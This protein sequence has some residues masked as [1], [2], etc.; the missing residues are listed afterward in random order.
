MAIKDLFSKQKSQSTEFR[1]A[2]KKSLDEFRE[3]VESSEEIKQIRIEDSLIQ[4]D[5]N[6]ASASSF[7]K[8]GSAKKYYEDAINRI[9]SQY[10]YDGSNKEKIEFRNDLTQLERHILDVDYP[11]ST[12]FAVFS[13]DGWGTSTGES[14]SFFVQSDTPEF[15]TAFGYQKNQI[16][17]TGSKQQQSFRLDFTTGFTVE[18]WLKKGTN[19]TG[20]QA[21][22]DIRDTVNRSASFGAYM[23]TSAPTSNLFVYYNNAVASNDFILTLPTGLGTSNT[24]WHHYAIVL[25]HADSDYKGKLYIDGEFSSQA[26]ATKTNVAQTGSLKLTI[27]ALGGD[28]KNHDSSIVAGYGKLS[29]SIDEFRFWQ[30]QRD[31]EQIGRNYFT[32]VNGG[33]NSDT[34]KVND[35]NT[36]KLASYFKFNEGKTGDTNFDTVALD[37]S[38]RLTNG[39]WTGY[40]SNSRDTG[41]AIV[42]SN[43]GTETGDP[44]IYST[45]PDVVTLSNNLEASGTQYDAENVGSLQDSLPLWMLDENEH[46]GGELLNLL[47]VMGSYLDSLYLQVTQMT[48]FHESEYQD[49]N[50]VTANPHNRRLL[51][52]LG[53]DIPEMFIDKDVLETIMDQ[54]DK[55]R[56]E[57]KL[58]DIKNLIYKNIYNNLNYINK[59]KGTVKSI[60]NL[61]R[62]YGIDDDL[63]NFN[64]YADKA[65]YFIEDDFKN[66]SIKFDSLDLTPFSKAQNSEGVIYNFAETGNANTAAFI[67][68]STDNYLGFTVQAN[69]IFPKTPS[70]YIDTVE[71][72]NP[73]VVTASVF[74]V[75][76]ASGSTVTTTIPNSNATIG[77]NIVR[78]DNTAKFHLTSSI[79]SGLSLESD[80]FYDVY[81]NSRWSLSLRVKYKGNDFSVATGSS[82]FAIELDGYNYTQDILENSFSLSGD[83]TN[84]NGISFVNANKRIY[85]GAEKTNITGTLIRR[86]NMKLLSVLSWADYLEQDELKSLA[87]DVTSFGRSRPYKNTFSFRSGSLGNNFI[88]KFDS[89]SMNIGFNQV[90]SSDSGGTFNVADLSS[91]SLTYATKYPDEN[92]SSI[93]GIQHSMKGQGFSESSDVKDIQY[94]N[95]STQQ[96]PENLNTDNMIEILSRDDD[97]FFIDARP[98]KYFFSLEASMYDT[99]SREMLKTFAGVL[100]YASMIGAPVVDFQ[101][102]PKQLRLARENFFERVQNKPDLDKFVKLYKFL[103]SAIESVLFNLMPASANASDTIRTVIENHLFERSHVVRL[104]PPG[105]KIDTQNTV[106]NKDV[107]GYPPTVGNGI[108]PYQSYYKDDAAAIKPEEATG[109]DTIG[110]FKFFNAHMQGKSPSLDV[111]REDFQPRKGTKNPAIQNSL[112]QNLNRY[113]N[114]RLIGAHDTT[115]TS[116][117]FKLRA[118][119]NNPDLL[120]HDSDT[121]NLKTRTSAHSALQ[122]ERQLN[123]TKGATIKGSVDTKVIGPD[124]APTRKGSIL[125]PIIQTEQ[126]K[127]TI[128]LT[129]EQHTP[130]FNTDITKNFLEY[131]V[132]IAGTTEDV[133]DVRLSQNNL[134][135][136][137]TQQAGGRQF[138][139]DGI[140][141]IVNGQHTDIFYDSQEPLQGPF[142]EQHAGGYKHRHLEVAETH[143]RPELFKVSVL[144]GLQT[145]LHNPRTNAAADE[146]NFDTPRVKFSRGMG[147]KTVYN[148]T[149]IATTTGSRTLGNFDKNYQVVMTN[150]RRENNFA[151]VEQNGFDV[152]Q[153]ESTAVSGVLD[154]ALPTRSLSN[155]TF[156]KTVIVNRFSSPGEIATLSEGFLD[157]EA[158]ELSPYNALPYRNRTVVNNLND[159]LK[160]PTARGGFE[161]GS[162]VTASF[163]KVQRNRVNRIRTNSSGAIITG[164]FEDNGFF[165]YQIPKSDFGYSW[166]AASAIAGESMDGLFGFATSSDGITFLSASEVGSY[167]STAFSGVRVYPVP[168]GESA[169][170]TGPSDFIPD[171][172]VGLNYHIYEPVDNESNTLGQPAGTPYYDGTG[173]VEYQNTIFAE[174]SN[175]TRAPALLNGLINKRNGPYTYPTFKQTRTGEHPVARHIKENN[176]IIAETDGGVRV[177]HAPVSTKYS[178]VIH[179]LESQEKFGRDTI[180]KDMI[181]SYPF[182]SEYDTY[183]NYFDEVDNTIKNPFPGKNFKDSDKRDSTLFNVSTLYT[184][185]STV[186]KTNNIKL[187]SLF[188]SE[189]VY[190]KQTNAY[191]SKT[192]DRSRFVFNWRDSVDSRANQLAGSQTSG[193]FSLWTMDRTST[194]IGE[195]MGLTSGSKPLELQP[196]Y[197]RYKVSGSNLGINEC[198]SSSPR[199][200]VHF[201]TTNSAGRGPFD[202]DYSA[203]NSEIRLMAKDH[204]IVPEYKISD[205]IGAIIDSGFNTDKDS[206][207][208]LSLTGSLSLQTSASFLETFASSDDIPAIEIIRQTQEKDADRISIKVSAAKKLLPYNGFYPSQRTLQ[209]STLFS[210]SLAPDATLAGSEPTFQTLN[211]VV[212][213]RL[214]YGSIRAGIAIDSVNFVGG[215][216]FDESGSPFPQADGGY[217]ISRIPFEAVVDPASFITPDSQIRENDP[218][219]FFDSTASV[220]YIDPK[221]SL[222]ASNFYAGVVDTFVQNSTLTSIRSAQPR[223]WNFIASSSYTNYVMDIVIS[224]KSDFTNHDDPGANGFPYVNHACFYQ[225]LNS[226]TD[227]ESN[228]KSVVDSGFSPLRYLSRA[229][230]QIAPNASWGY[231]EATVTID[232]DYETFK[233]VVTDRDPTLNDIFYYSTKTYK[234]KQMVDLDVPSSDAIAG[235]STLNATSA[236]MTIEAGLDLYVVNENGQWSPTTRWECPTHNYVGVDALYPDGT[237]GGTGITGSNVTRGVWHQYSTDT[238]SGLKMFA[239]GPE[240]GTA[241]TTGSLAKALGFSQRQEV[242]SQLAA[243]THL[244]E[245][246]VV[247]PFVTN[248]EQEE[249]FFHYPIDTFE[250]AYSNIGKERRGT[251][252]D[253][254]ALQRDLILPPRLNYMDRRD[255]ADKRLEQ[256]EYGSILPPFAMY[257]FEVTE[258]LKQEDLSKWWQG[259]LPSAGEKVTFETF[260]INHKI[261]DG[262]IIGPAVLKNEMFRG[263]LPK[264]MRFK[265]FKAKYRR[266]LTYEEIKA[267]S[268]NGVEPSNSIFGYNYPHDYY[269]LIEMAKVDIGLEYEGPGDDE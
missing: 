20:S 172:F 72:T 129:L 219:N 236:N 46:E 74:G 106:G 123:I 77:I 15:I 243:S 29:G 102:Y 37:Y 248:Q 179:L 60:R 19:P 204:S 144:G 75:R 151:F 237:D 76:A 134:P 78:E 31:A 203:W 269:S 68:G 252:S 147:I 139:L 54:D 214:T 97:K 34:A 101:V 38:G 18:F 55:R 120:V 238:N 73:A 63:F 181:L 117:F 65:E 150:G 196:R 138:F 115:G 267:K 221:Y 107:T 96:I 69:T 253:S 225:P 160:I 12:G 216:Y 14:D 47:Q 92:Y 250:A 35:D 116:A 133:A 158:A 260:N 10:P 135:V 263:K 3:D 57:D 5:L 244:K 202:D 178:P 167:F 131:N 223:N 50:S 261:S 56:F 141:S 194:V 264:E 162:A 245:Y 49:N 229:N 265:V 255:S 218:E 197:G 205:N 177:Q 201:G 169:T 130:T 145:V 182:A 36:L 132:E 118:K 85:A 168:V 108:A 137:F 230:N 212:F 25:N 94:L 257:V 231:N 234:N 11:K 91:G 84:A 6:Y 45:H 208:G 105:R 193:T 62:C 58:N 247:I 136:K 99:I 119:R 153:S 40:V 23:I 2:H 111:V 188:Y 159:F 191:L 176:L 113:D 126:A 30:E 156:N 222:A 186:R 104:L 163:H 53:F 189:T 87:R 210:Q 185:K 213:S 249:T 110:S 173:G 220:G 89:L 16:F 180:K 195:L 258:E 251:L 93:V 184:G 166:I 200:T 209:L 13:P 17:D 9:Y 262:E 256:D 109:E 7:V 88:P 79:G 192:R 48:K 80:R 28:F 41:S 161:S 114:K 51:T 226:P 146:Y 95:I 217:Q 70:T 124:D 43:A 241:R 1:G 239:R 140:G 254:L 61:L 183:G 81:D 174:S 8:Y 67:S 27:G 235:I 143:E 103:D 224:K 125:L 121:G 52:S 152:Q 26:S 42:Q 242:V 155:G 215:A 82:N 266:N 246:L 100:D 149:N 268:L 171:T 21:I 199:N 190:P 4:P 164:S 122:R 233:N 44:I 232:F 86:S 259:V 228:W 198:T 83:I 154:F 39:A 22:F 32:V 33:G 175:A 64:V 66:S 127:N 98:V 211:N 170:I 165:N 59:S 90:T 187:T 142:T 112:E 24:D 227:T 240:A 207:Q 206:F 148:V 128:K 71:L 157:V